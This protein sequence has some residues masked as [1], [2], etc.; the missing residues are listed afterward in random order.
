MKKD[1]IKKILAAAAGMAVVV[2]SAAGCTV[3]GH[4]VRIGSASA[5][6][7]YYMVAN[8]LADL[9][10]DEIEDYEFE[11]R[12]TTG[13]VANLRLLSDNYIQLGI[14]QADIIITH[15]TEMVSTKERRL[16]RDT[17]RLEACIQK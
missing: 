8:T 7:V 5:G 11:V 9:A 4:T 3:P 15:I 1:K 13:S 12:A 16:F 6:A 17:V 2:S 10:E 14:A